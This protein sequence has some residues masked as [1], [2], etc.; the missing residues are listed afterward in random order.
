MFM[1]KTKSGKM[2]QDSSNLCKAR[3]PSGVLAVAFALLFLNFI[4]TPHAQITSLVPNPV[5]QGSSYSIEGTCP[6]SGGC[7]FIQV[8][9][10]EGGGTCASTP[11]TSNCP[12]GIYGGSSGQ[13]M[14]TQVGM[15]TVSG[16]Y[17]AT[18]QAVISSAGS[19]P[20]DYCGYATSTTGQTY[21]DSIDEDIIPNCLSGT[22]ASGAKSATFCVTGS[23]KEGVNKTA[24][25]GVVIQTG[26]YNPVNF[27]VS[28]SVSSSPFPVYACGAGQAG[29]NS[30]G[31]PFMVFWSDNPNYCPDPGGLP[32][33]GPGG[34]SLP[35]CGP[36][37]FQSGIAGNSY[38]CVLGWGT[39]NYG[40]SSQSGSCTFDSGIY[41]D[42]AVSPGK[43]G[44]CWWFDIPEGAIGSKCPSPGSDTTYTPSSDEFTFWSPTPTATYTV[45]NTAQAYAGV[46]GA[47]TIYADPSYAA[48][49]EPVVASLST[50]DG[51]AAPLWLE[52]SNPY[53]NNFFGLSTQNY[54]IDPTPG[55]IVSGTTVPLSAC[56]SLT[57]SSE[58]CNLGYSGEPGS[59]TSSS[60]LSANINTAGLAPGVYELCGYE[61]WPINSQDINTGFNTGSG[62]G[63][64]PAASLTAPVYYATTFFTIGC[65]VSGCGPVASEGGNAVS[66]SPVQ[67]IA[68]NLYS[69]ISVLIFL[70]ALTIM[71]IGAALFTGANVL[72]GQSRGVVK[73]YGMGLFFAGLVGVVMT[74]I[75]LWLLTTVA[76]V[77]LSN[78]LLQNSCAANAI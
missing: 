63:A 44:L 29:I 17:T 41:T 51:G 4:S 31:C 58:D 56:S 6:S 66:V 71:I 37:S 28:V 48:P 34:G 8:D 45:S 20:D 24:S 70:L 1:D 39:C 50:T 23:I 19:G 15:G 11:A 38:N 7:S 27:S 74:L 26:A 64:G 32:V 46:P 2:T 77:S 57:D 54:C 65:G 14:V 76:N 12:I 13:C 5:L 75:S 18:Q 33:Y 73:G 9:Y 30:C 22:G 72:P 49:G 25:S 68:C 35:L 10:I 43:Y 53:L 69:Q 62:S 42:A 59:Y 67:L 61:G 47:L 21:T 40:G 55:S 52:F 16:T 60:F 3:L 78:V 36:D